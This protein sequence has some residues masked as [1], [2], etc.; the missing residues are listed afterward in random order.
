LD[1]QI[2]TDISCSVRTYSAKIARD[3]RK[4][5]ITDTKCTRTLCLGV[6][7]NSNLGGIPARFA[8]TPAS[9]VEWFA[10]SEEIDPAGMEVVVRPHNSDPAAA[11]KFVQDRIGCRESLDNPSHILSNGVIN[12][13]T[14][15]PSDHLDRRLDVL[16]EADNVSARFDPFCHGM[17]R[18]PDSSAVLMSEDHHQGDTQMLDGILDTPYGR[19]IG[20]MTGRSNDEQVTEAPVEDDFRRDARIRAP[21]HDS[22]GVLLFG[23][24]A[25]PLDRMIRM[26]GFGSDDPSISFEQ[27]PQRF[28]RSQFPPFG[29]GGRFRF[30]AAS[31]FGPKGAGHQGEGYR[32]GDTGA[33]VAE[34]S[35]I[36][37]H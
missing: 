22:E 3:V 37:V 19:I 21:D 4:V 17:N 12:K 16:H 30:L 9:V 14:G 35:S 33:D 6:Y 11:S 20:G 29:G 23:H 34:I 10:Y 32:A 25:T 8:L 31:P 27:L 1:A 7:L 24:R 36:N 15:T 26:Q 18:R 28:V 5:G 2:G 13:V